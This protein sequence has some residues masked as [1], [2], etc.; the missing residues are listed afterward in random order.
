M[1]TL[2]D[3]SNLVRAT[4]SISRDS[5]IQRSLDDNHVEEG[6]VVSAIAAGDGLGVSISS[7]VAY[8]GGTR[9]DVSGQANLVATAAD[10]TLGRIDVVEVD[11]S[12]VQHYV[13]G[14]AAASPAKP[15]VS[16]TGR[17]VIAAITRPA[18]DD[19]IAT[20]QCDN[21]YRPKRSTSSLTFWLKNRMV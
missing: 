2:P 13:A 8:V 4:G 15:K 20:T 19:T 3:G 6:L 9:L 1:P 17:I 16:A 11:S 5:R 18:N 7:G 14:T 21:D 10:G 12:G